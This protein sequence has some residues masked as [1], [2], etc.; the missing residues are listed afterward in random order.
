MNDRRF[1]AAPIALAALLFLLPCLYVGSYLALVQRGLPM[2]IDTDNGEYV[3]TYRVG[4][5]IAMIAYSPLNALDRRVR[6]AYWT[7]PLFSIEI[8]PS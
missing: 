5:H 3:A 6:P 8:G 4:S 7:Q 2:E 1:P